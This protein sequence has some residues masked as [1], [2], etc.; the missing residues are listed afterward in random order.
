[1]RRLNNLSLVGRGLFFVALMFV[2]ALTAV[3]SQASQRP[4]DPPAPA[5]SASDVLDTEGFFEVVPVVSEPA[6]APAVSTAPF[7]ISDDGQLQRWSASEWIN[8]SGLPSRATAL[9][10]INES[11]VYVGTEAMG[12]FKST[13]A[14]DTWAEVNNA[15]L[16]LVP[17][18][19]LDITA[20]TVDPED[21]DHVFAATAYYFGSTQVKRVPAGVYESRDGGKTWQ[22]LTESRLPG[23]VTELKLDSTAPGLLIV[24]WEVEGD[25][26]LGLAR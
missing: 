6:L 13:D 5:A 16:G 8:V 26:H 22:A 3:T 12:L 7:R 1:M 10:A 17:G 21:A 25:M 2:L 19:V 14:G 18:S 23:T 9:A 15:E 20:L 24:H 4:A 11:T